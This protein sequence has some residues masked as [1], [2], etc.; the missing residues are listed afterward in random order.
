[1]PRSIFSF[2]QGVRKHFLLP[3]RGAQT[4]SL[5]ED[6]FFFFARRALEKRVFFAWPAAHGAKKKTRPLFQP[7]TAADVPVSE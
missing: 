7:H 4:V 2:P 3:A 6:V 5:S 1:M